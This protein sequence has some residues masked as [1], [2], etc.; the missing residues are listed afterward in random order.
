M[1]KSLPDYGKLDRPK[2][3]DVLF[4]PRRDPYPPAVPPAVDHDIEVDQGVRVGVRLYPAEFD[5]APNIIFFHGNGEIAADYDTVGPIYNRRGLSLLV[6]DYRGYGRSSGVPTATTMMR[7][8][9]VIF[10]WAHRWLRAGGH[11]GPIVV[12]GR[13]LGSA[14]ALEVAVGYQDD[15]AG[16]I[17]ESAFAQTLP[18]LDRLGAD[19]Q[20]MSLTEADGFQNLEKIARITK[21]TLIIHARHDE[22]IPVMSAELLQVYCGARSKE[23]HVIPAAGHNN[24]FV[25]AGEL[26]F[27]LIQRFTNRLQ[28]KFDKRFFRKTTQRRR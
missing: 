28:G 9:H 11:T 2:I 24:I 4:H 22:I 17:L 13:S 8:A 19:T 1:T 5:Q 15:L 12:M 14:C 20:A 3:L 16:L 18:L 10:E 26:Y 6:A 21:P 7:D 23:F 27:E 25:Y